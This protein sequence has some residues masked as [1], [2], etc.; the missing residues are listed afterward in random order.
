MEKSFWITMEDQVEVYVK[1][2]FSAGKQPKAIV[3]IAHG[4]IEHIERYNDFASYL[5]EQGIFI[6]GNDHR[7]HGNTGEKQG[8]MGYF[9]D[10]DGFRHAAEDL[11]VITMEIKQDYP[12]VPVF[13]FGHSMGSFLVRHFLH[14]YSGSVQGAILSGTG[15]TPEWKLFAARLLANSLPPKEESKLINSL[16]FANYNKKIKGNKTKFDWLSGNEKLVDEYIEDHYTGF[17]PTARF[18]YDLMSGIK[19]I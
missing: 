18:F 11:Y 10:E 5:L 6:Y 19:K 13:L 3:Q 17:I 12:Q 9:S 4:M 1:K 16:V 7:G 15:F 14:K 8:I 2:W